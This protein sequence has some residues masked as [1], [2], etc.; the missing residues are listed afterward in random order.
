VKT[1]TTHPKENTTA[2]TL[3][4]PLGSRLPYMEP[5]KVPKVYAMRQRAALSGTTRRTGGDA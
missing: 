2:V 3:D 4:R 5:A 1:I